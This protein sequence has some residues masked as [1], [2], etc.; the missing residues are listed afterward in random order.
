MSCKQ[1]RLGTTK[2]LSEEPE[3][4]RGVILSKVKNL[5]RN[6]EERGFVSLNMT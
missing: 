6:A 1:R 3:P 4:P 2:S 5:S